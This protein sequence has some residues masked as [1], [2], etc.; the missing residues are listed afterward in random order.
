MTGCHETPSGP[1]PG[2]A[3][4]D[5]YVAVQDQPL[6]V[7]A[8]AGLLSN[9]GEGAS[10]VAEADL[11]SEALGV[12]EVDDDGGFRYSP[13]AGVWGVDAFSYT[14]LAP[15]LPPSRAEVRVMILPVTLDLGALLESGRGWLVDGPS[16]EGLG[17]AVVGLADASGD[18]LA[19][20]VIAAP[21]AGDGAGRAYLVPGGAALRGP[22]EVTAAAELWVAGHGGRTFTGE[23]AGDR[24]ASAIA[25]G[26]LDGDGLG[27]LV[28]CAP[29]RDLVDAEAG[30]CYVIF[31]RKLL[32]GPFDLSRIAAGDGGFVIEGDGEASWTGVAAASG[33]DLNNDGL[34]DLVIGAPGA[35]APEREQ[36][37]VYVI[38]GRSGGAPVSLVAIA[39]G[40]GGYALAGRSP[41][42]RAGAAVAMIGDVDGDHLG[43]LAVA[44][45]LA[46]VDEVDGAGRVY[47][48]R[49]TGLSGYVVATLFVGEGEGVALG[50]ALAALGDV[51]GD[52]RPDLAI[53]APDAKIRKSAREG[54][55]YVV[56]GRTYA[57][58]V[59][60]AAAAA[61]GDA[62]RIRGERHLAGGCG[63]AL[64][65]AGDVDGD[66]LA[67]LLIGAPALDAGASGGGRAYVVFGRAEGGTIELADVALGIGGFAIDGELAEGGAGTGL[68]AVGDVD[69]DG[70]IDLAI[71]APR[72][73]TRG[74]MSGH[75]AVIFGFG[76][77]P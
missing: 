3:V 12:V 59:D 60:L 19:E 6:K 61:A 13:P 36:G 74:A 43:D 5:F 24:L 34:D 31:G 9:D 21:A 68:A 28:L 58:D 11:V 54:E 41:F 16:G 57:G 35:A 72:A 40:T 66:G 22:H 26:D 32:Q 67:D 38:F 44:A 47:M 64:A 39:A 30:R 56:Y 73:G 50:S 63:R 4:V 23:A 1:D 46:S 65:A 45:P 14:V 69:G 49:G 10:A 70:R 52:G 37:R 53:G 71:G 48:V 29:H 55:V 8:D 42:E 25:S 62:L 18:G 2:I 15:E 33:A 77:P 51:D 17:E 7:D 27:D 76:A 20:L 75:L